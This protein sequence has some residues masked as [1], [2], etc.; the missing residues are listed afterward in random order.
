MNTQNLKTEIVKTLYWI[1]EM[2]LH[3]QHPNSKDRYYCLSCT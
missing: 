3:P 1:N 2:G